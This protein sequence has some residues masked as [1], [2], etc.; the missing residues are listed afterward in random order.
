MALVEGTVLC[1]NLANGAG[2]E[3]GASSLQQSESAV[4][5]FHA[6]QPDLIFLQEA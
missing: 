6:Y 5:L 1:A 2:Q 3:P 4:A